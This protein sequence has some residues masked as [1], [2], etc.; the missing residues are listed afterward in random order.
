MGHSRHFE[1]VGD[2]SGLPSTP[3][4]LL[5]H[6]EPTLRAA[7]AVTGATLKRVV[8]E[9]HAK[10]QHFLRLGDPTCLQFSDGRRGDRGGGDGP[11][12]FEGQSA[13]VVWYVHKVRARRLFHGRQAHGQPPQT[14][15]LGN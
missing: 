5:Q 10:P 7:N 11:L 13:H 3:D 1:A 9:P 6:N 2:E 4:G 8:G 14:V 12:V 15:A